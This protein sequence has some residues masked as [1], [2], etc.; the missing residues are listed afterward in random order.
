MAV[1]HLNDLESHLTDLGRP[2]AVCHLTAEKPLPATYPSASLP[3]RAIQG[4]SARDLSGCATAARVALA[5]P[6]DRRIASAAGHIVAGSGSIENA[7]N[8]AID[9]AELQPFVTYN[10]PGGG[11]FLHGQ[12]RSPASAECSKLERCR[13][14]SSSASTT[15]SLPQSTAPV[16]KPDLKSNSCRDRST[17]R[18]CS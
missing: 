8:Q 7:A 18:C 10:I 17:N 1:W 11:D 15:M 4:C 3:T 9:L 16:G 2:N 12:S 6:A 14:S 13:Q 5:T